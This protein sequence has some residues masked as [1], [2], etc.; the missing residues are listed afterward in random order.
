M[1]LYHDTLKHTLKHL[2]DII[3]YGITIFILL[4]WIIGGPKLLI[5]H[6]FG[7]ISIIAHW[8]VNNGR[9]MISEICGHEDNKFTNGILNT[10]NIDIQLN[11]GIM[12]ISL[13]V[14]ATITYVR[15]YFIYS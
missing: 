4:G 10:L 1:S 3:H 9:C 13:F 5:F 6:L 11:E 14:L 7:T 15:L 12:Y 2:L 8:I